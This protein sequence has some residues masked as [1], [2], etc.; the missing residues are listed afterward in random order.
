MRQEAVP[1]WSEHLYSPDQFGP[2]EGGTLFEGNMIVFRC[3]LRA[4]W[5]VKRPAG[6][7]DLT[8]AGA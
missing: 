3:E 7:V 8:V 5:A 4:G 6:I 2:G 1:D